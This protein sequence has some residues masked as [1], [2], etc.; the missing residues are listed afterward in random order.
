LLQKTFITLAFGKV[1]SAENS[2][3]ELVSLDN[4]DNI[5]S[6]MRSSEWTNEREASC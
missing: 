6:E 3:L 4:K 5:L 2:T 1:N